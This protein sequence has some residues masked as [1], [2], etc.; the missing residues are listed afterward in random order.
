MWSFESTNKH[1]QDNMKHE[2]GKEKDRTCC[3]KRVCPFSKEEL[4]EYAEKLQKRMDENIGDV[5]LNRSEWHAAIILR[6]FIESARK[7]IIIFCGHLNKTVYGDLLPSFQAAAKRGVKIRV[8][9]ASSHVCATEVADGLRKLGAFQTLGD[10]E[11][12][13]PH[14][15]VVDGLRYRLE[16]NDDDKAAIVCAYAST[17]EHMRRIVKIEH[18]FNILWE[19]SL[20]AAE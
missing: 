9:T 2:T 3:E 11:E 6:K 7:S 14:F 16:T 20:V 1:I 5:F 8:L 12:D 17:R 13:A 10:D 15:T 18:L 4:R 19:D